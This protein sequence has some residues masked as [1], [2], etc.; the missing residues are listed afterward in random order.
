M[1]YAVKKEEE[2]RLASVMR[3]QKTAA[4]SGPLPNRPFEHDRKYFD[5]Y[6]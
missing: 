1:A 6:G 2:L 5:I 3:R 4:S